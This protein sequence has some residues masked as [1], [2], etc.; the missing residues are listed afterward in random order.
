MSIKAHSPP[1]KLHHSKLSKAVHPAAAGLRIQPVDAK[2]E[3][4][5]L[6]RGP[7]TELVRREFVGE[8]AISET[9]KSIDKESELRVIISAELMILW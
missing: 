7:L 2:R 4:V 6:Q 3:A 9:V 8:W 1:T 5:A